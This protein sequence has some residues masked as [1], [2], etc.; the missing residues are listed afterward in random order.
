M[1][2]LKILSILTISF[3]CTLA[4]A[5]G[6]NQAQPIDESRRSTP[7]R[8]MTPPSKG[9]TISGTFS[10]VYVQIKDQ[11]PVRRA[12]M[13]ATLLRRAQQ[14]VP[15]VVIVDNADSYLFAISNWEAMIRFPIL[16]DDGTP[17]SREDIA[18]FVRAFKPEQ[19]LRI[20]GQS[21]SP[22]VGD[23]DAKQKVFEK[24]LS[25]AVDESIG[26]WKTAFDRLAEREL[27]SPGMVVTDVTDP[28]WTAAIA[29]CAGRLQPI[30][31]INK[32]STPT[33]LP[34]SML[35]ADNLERSIERAASLSGRSWDEIGDDIDAI[36]LAMNTGTMIK[37]GKLAL[38]DRLGRTEA[39]GS[40]KRWAWCGQIIG[41]ESRSVYQAM[42]SLF[43]SIDQGFIWDGYTSKQPWAQYD[44]TE[45]GKILSEKSFDVEVHDQPK[46]T[47]NDWKLR[48]VRPI[49]KASDSDSSGALIML[50]NSKGPSNVFDL[51]GSVDGQGKPGH[52]PVMNV[53]TA[54]HIV[55]SF[56]LQRPIARTSVGGRF[57]ERGVYVYAG[58]VDEPYLNAFVPTPSIA[59]RLAGSLAFS[60]AIHYDDNKV[61]KI[62]VLGDPLVTFGH[63][64]QRIE[65]KIN[66]PGSIDIEERYKQ[67]LKDKDY[68]G[69]IL[70]LAMLG[71]DKDVARIAIALM[72]DQP[73][74]FSPKSAFISIPSLFRVGEYTKMIDAYE[75]LDAFGQSHAL[76]QDLLW[77][78]SPYLLARSASQV[79]ER[80]R[81]EALLRSNIRTDQSIEDA[82]SLAMAMRKHSPDNAIGILEA[83]RPTLSGRDLK[84]LDRAIARARK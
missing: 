53:P 25:M 55:H 61:W 37:E 32:P 64:G 19:V 80:S 27:I 9:S 50:M 42:C 15:I 66:V 79:D 12:G 16:W 35:D 40:G 23:R 56:S 13:R 39:S 47:L 74:L 6:S 45:A 63:A 60:T 28:A 49:G 70:D 30:A 59:R 43:L 67:L 31:F 76:M 84:R 62:T 82:E 34:I 20:S 8:L 78:S 5:Q 14:V 24:T 2:S 58:S 44:G 52:L 75:R 21:D 33:V 1:V 10:D 11:D 51:P 54:L 77:L 3:L 81:I 48:M 17:N 36:T 26:N 83:L 46:Y 57:I 41:A 68:Q 71:R 7:P 72:S 4:S 18:R 73:D 65:G 69:A 22:W 29:L 38:T